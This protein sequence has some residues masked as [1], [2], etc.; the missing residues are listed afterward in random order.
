MGPT[1]RVQ[2]L[3]YSYA[4]LSET[5]ST[6]TKSFFGTNGGKKE[7][8]NK[9]N[10]QLMRCPSASCWFRKEGFLCAQPCFGP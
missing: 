9:K 2:V 10:L 8:L 1:R 4:A 7:F 6:E 3:T 5:C